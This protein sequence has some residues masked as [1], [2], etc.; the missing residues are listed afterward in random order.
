M[1]TDFGHFEE[2]QL[3]RTYDVKLLRRLYPFI[4][5]Y[6]LLIS[7]SLVLVIL[8]ALMDIALPYITKIAIDR[9]I[10][11]QYTP[12]ET[13]AGRPEKEPDK[14]QRY[15]Q[16]DLKNGDIR[17]IVQANA[18]RFKIE[19]ESAWIALSALE[20]F[21]SAERAILREP[22]MTGLAWLT[23]AFLAIIL[24][25]FILNFLQAMVME[26]TGQMVMHG[27]RT[28]LFDHIQSMTVS[29]FTRHPVGRLVTR[30]TNDIQNMH[31]LF[32]SV[33]ATVFKDIF[34]LIGIAAVLLSIHWQLALISY[35]VLPVVLLASIYFASRSREAFRTLR[36]K[37][38][39]INTRFSETLGGIK[40]V[41]LFQQERNNFKRFSRTNHENY[42]AGMM[43]VQVFAVFLPI[44]EMLGSVALAGI[45][46]FGGSRV[47]T[48]TMSLGDL[49]AFIFY[50]RMF[51]RP[52]RDIAEKY[53]ILQNA[54]AS[55]ERI[56]LILDNREQLPQPAQPS[57]PAPAGDGRIRDIAFDS[58]SFSYVLD[59]PVLRDVS[60]RITAGETVAVVGPTGSGKTSLINL[61]LRF[62]DPTAGRV[63][64]NGMDIR[65]MSTATLRSRM[66]L[67]TQDPFLFSGTIRD[68][69]NQ[70][71]R[72][73]SG[74]ELDRMLTVSQCRE[75]IDRLP[76]GMDTRISEGGKTL[77]SGERQ[78]LS[79]ARAFA[80]DPELIIL[81]EATSYIDSDTEQKIQAALAQLMAKRTS[82]V[83]A[84][85]LATVRNADRILVLNKGRIIESGTHTE[86]MGR[87][88]FYYKLNQLQS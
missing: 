23:A 30:V 71:G 51:F 59:E 82:I 28:R 26:Y 14:R 87:R 69:I 25:N 72:R 60:F 78:F 31:E 34:L 76:D 65:D 42:L 36:I 74:T 6:K 18:D 79:I 45:I 44:I 1:R 70:H 47:L 27:L 24:T 57:G 68:N 48:E 63:Q 33:I 86:L 5:P 19:G 35:T 62:Y 4:R 64:I 11:P 7:A 83:V 88:G 46:Y 67:V 3:G 43:Q 9:Y 85:R 80:R 66:A 53:N 20:D 54:L 41:Q 58:V 21:S 73:L 50:M 52:I 17:T 39:E 84:H 32:T 12:F 22:H 16:V 40:V 56:F 55:A 15:L 81:D 2:E 10:V 38:A 29:F 8:I 37:V 49:S 13:P 75:L 77:S 61:I